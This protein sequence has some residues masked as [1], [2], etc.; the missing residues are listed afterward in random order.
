MDTVRTEDAVGMVLGHDMTEIIPGE[1]KGV[2]FKKGHIIKEEDIERL[3]RIGKEHIYV[4][5]LKEGEIHENEAAIRMG[6][7]FAGSG[8]SFNEPHEG[9]ISL[10]P[11]YEGLLKINR[12]LLDDVNSIDG[13]C[14][15]T[16]PENIRVEKDDLLGG[17]RIIPLTIEKEIIDDIEK[18]T[19]GK[20][21][22]FQVKEFIPH[23]VALI[24][25]GSEVYK[26]R[27]EDKFG[28]IIKRKVESYNSTLFNKTIVDDSTE[29]IK[30]AI[31]DAK[32]MG[33]EMIIVTGGMSVDPD[34]K[35]PGAIKSTGAHIVTYGTPVLPGAMLLLAY[36]DDIPVF[37][38]PGGVLFSE[39]T[40]FDLIL[41]RVLVGE[42][43][44][45]RDITKMGY[46]G[47][48]ISCDLCTYPN[49]HFGKH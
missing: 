32:E 3:L 16:I 18:M 25:T 38:L 29:D 23:K 22:L 26:G 4:F 43:L 46:G 11:E 27:I 30:K 15:A 1:F 24:V 42:K 6:N 41:P 14:I 40:S 33:A 8:I 47:Q 39:I 5:N 36:L 31:F 7:M 2:A 19:K 21:K 35:T 49:C 37:G 13:M 10:R 34:D 17:C 12:D 48:C 44:V 9:K 28:P 45:K 20:E